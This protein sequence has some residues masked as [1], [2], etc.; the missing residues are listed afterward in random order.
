MINWISIKDALWSLADDRQDYWQW[1]ATIL[2]L[3]AA[4]LISRL[5]KKTLF[6]HSSAFR[7]FCVRF[8][9]PGEQ[10]NGTPI[11]FCTLLW[12]TWAIRSHW[13]T[14]LVN[15]GYSA[16]PSGQIHTIALL[17]SAYVVYQISNAISKGHFIP[18]VLSGGMLFIFTLH[19]L[20]WLEP[21]SQALQ[22]IAIP[23]GDLQIN[24]WNI[25]SGAASLLLLMW[26]VSLANRFIDAAINSRKDIPPTIKVLISKTSRLSLYVFAIAGALSIGGVP[27]GGLTIFSGALGLGL[28]FGLQKI[29]ANLISGLIILLDKSIKPGD[30]IEID[31]TFGWIN[32]IHTR[33][34]SVITRDRKE[35]LVPNED[36]VTNKV[37]NWS[38][39]DRVIRIKADIGVSYD[40]D[41]NKAIQLCTEAVA[42]IPRTLTDPAPVCLLKEFGDSC[43]NLQVRFCI[44]DAANG[45][46]NVR[47]QV[48]LAIWQSFRDNHIEIPFPQRDI[49][50]KS[51]SLPLSA[52]AENHPIS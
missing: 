31:G 24:L 19:L 27:L 42:G 4:I 6:H 48:L 25:L 29:I 7:Q 26:I 50:I 49:H 43:I 13:S 39:S 45:V 22:K 44:E 28:G 23:L 52:P 11:I 18:R 38:Y 1:G 35:F 16:I 33:Y 12:L 36:F 3:V 21:V 34:V 32:S 40:T 30:V 8:F 41:L 15:G 47:S 37:I 17:V 20:S 51:G 14:T 5:L 10:I 9:N 46:S 2:C